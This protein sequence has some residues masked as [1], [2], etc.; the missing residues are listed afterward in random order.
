MN[1]K[2]T[3]FQSKRDKTAWAFGAFS[4]DK[5]RVWIATNDGLLLYEYSTDSYDWFKYDANEKPEN[6]LRNRIRSIVVEADNQIW[7]ACRGG[8]VVGFK[9]PTQTWKTY[10]YTS[11]SVKSDSKNLVI[12]LLSKQG[13]ADELWV[14][15]LENSLGI[16]NKTTGNFEFFKNNPINRHSII[17]NEVNKVFYDKNNTLWI[18]TQKGISIY[19]ERFQHFLPKPILQ[20]SPTKRKFFGPMSYAEIGNQ[21][22]L[23]MNN[24]VGLY[25]LDKTSNQLEIIKPQGSKPDDFY[26]FVRMAKDTKGDLWIVSLSD[27]FK[28][29]PKTKV[30]TNI[31]LPNPYSLDSLKSQSLSFDKNGMLYVGT[32]R[33]GILRIDPKTFEIKQFSKQKDKNS[34]AANGYI[35][36]ILCDKSGILWIATER[37]VSRFDPKTEVFTNFFDGDNTAPKGVKTIY[38]LVEDKTGLIWLTTES[39]GAYAIDPKSLKFVK[40][41]KQ[42][43]GLSSNAINGLACDAYNGIW[44]ATTK[45]LCYYDQKTN[46]VLVFDKKNGLFQENLD[47]GLANLE[48]QHIILG[49]QGAYTIFNPAEIRRQRNN[50]LPVITN[51]YVFEKP[52]EWQQNQPIRLNYKQNFFGFEFSA[53]DFLIPEKVKYSYRLAGIDNEW[54]E[55]NGSDKANYTNLEAGK[56]TF[57]LRATPQNSQWPTRFSSID[58][59]ISPPFWL[60]WWFIL[61]CTAFAVCAAYYL[62]HKKIE[63][64]NRE[65]EI[66]EKIA[67]L[68]MTALRS[69]MNPH[70]IFNSLNTVRYFV[71]S[72]QKEKAKDYLSKFSKL[73][74]TIL[75]YSKENTISLSNE[76][77]AIRLYLDVELG[78]FE[79]NFYYNI[80]TDAEI[81][82]DSVMIPPLLLQSFAENAIIYGLRNSEKTDKILTIK[83]SQINDETLEISITDNGIGRTKANKLQHNQDSLHKSFGTAITNQRI[84]LFNQNYANKIKVET[85]DLADELGTQV[86]ISIRI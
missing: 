11:E 42:K 32:R 10:V 34:I 14:S 62:Y 72:E 25:I 29:S 13:T 54:I 49:Y 31:K 39:E 83:V 56:Y 17:A 60:T 46:E 40:N 86:V 70:F 24:S 23:G 53:L 66:K 77:N 82:L 1:K 59:I 69:Q 8:G 51:F 58:V 43:D 28:Y 73:L 36:E 7:L 63:T 75:T 27:L 47:L 68:E 81:G 15:T 55:A 22:F 38:R 9:Y 33:R 80:E 52:F 4:G 26:S 76:L 2:S 30:L 45:G 3:K 79:S 35:Q 16:F 19:T 44:L 6:D 61:L 20:K 48:N 65:S 41:I 85:T 18:S 71:I 5:N 21:L 67:Q 50:H 12:H 57:Q 84:E 74:R 78:R 37:G 64:L